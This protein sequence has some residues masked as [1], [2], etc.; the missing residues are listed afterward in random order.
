MLAELLQGNR[1]VVP[2]RG[3]KILH[4][5]DYELDLSHSVAQR[6]RLLLFL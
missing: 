5:G 3:L 4:I 1:D 6:S 2:C